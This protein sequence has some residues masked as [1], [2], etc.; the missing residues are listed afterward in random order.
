M[1]KM[2]NTIAL[3]SSDIPCIERLSEEFHVIPLPR[4]DEIDTPV[5]THPDMICT[6]LGGKLFFPESYAK[7]N[8]ALID[9]IKKLSGT[10]IVLS[11]AERGRKYPL[12][13]SLNTAV[14]GNYLLCRE[15]STSRELLSYAN[16]C[17]MTVLDTKQ[18]YSGCSCI[19]C[20][21]NVVTSD[22]GIYKLLLSTGITCKLTQ[23]KITLD[24][25]N[26]GFIGGC[27]GY[28]DGRVYLFGESEE[29]FFGCETVSLMNG[30]ITD[31]GGIKFIPITKGV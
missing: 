3:V 30:G 19:V 11:K 4:D 23:E 7:K 17:G 14:I 24:G 31:Y 6:Y 1:G 16:E 12:D 8:S 2:K 22:V 20:G 21:E 18:G 29:N 25:Y 9:E 15:K 26:C 28:H 10:D 13:V 27:G 5:S